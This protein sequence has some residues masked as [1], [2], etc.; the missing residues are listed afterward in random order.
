MD[1]FVTYLFSCG[2]RKV[3]DGFGT[4]MF[5][6]HSCDP[7]AR[8][9]MT[10]GGYSSWRSDIAAGRAYYEYNLHDGDEEGGA[11]VERICRGRCSARKR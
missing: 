4:A 9:R 2:R 7:I 5:I 11:T 6:N 8:L 10:M 1:R 3:I